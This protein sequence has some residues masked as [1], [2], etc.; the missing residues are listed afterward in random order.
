HGLR[1]ALPATRASSPKTA[2]TRTSG[3]TSR[4]FID[5]S[6]QVGPRSAGSA[7]PLPAPSEGVSVGATAPDEY[8]QATENN[9]IDAIAALPRT[10]L[11]PTLLSRVDGARGGPVRSRG[12]GCP[13][14]RTESAAEDVSTALGAHCSNPGATT[15]KPR[16]AEPFAVQRSPPP[17]WGGTGWGGSMNEQTTT[18]PSGSSCAA[19]GT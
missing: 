3:M 12:R 5:M 4:P 7:T 1:P 8:P 15:K 11:K 18:P 2:V 17:T 9:A 6:R 13:A 10:Y 14:L 19:V 16:R